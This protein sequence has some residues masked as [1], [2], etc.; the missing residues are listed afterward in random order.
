ML[1]LHGALL[2]SHTYIV[3]QT[4]EPALDGSAVVSDPS[5]AVNL[6]NVSPGP[7][8][9]DSTCVQGSWKELFTEEPLKSIDMRTLEKSVHQKRSRN[10]RDLLRS[11]STFSPT[12]WII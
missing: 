4:S 1:L 8:Q 11:T 6:I 2:G 10:S 12:N 5:V 3:R 7:G 9:Q